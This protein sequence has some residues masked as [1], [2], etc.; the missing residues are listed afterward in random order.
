MDEAPDSRAP[1]KKE[2]SEGEKLLHNMFRLLQVVKIHQANNKLFSDSVVAFRQVLM[3]MW[4]E[5]SVAAFA[6]Y[7]GRFYLNDTRIVYTPSMWATSAKMM[8]YFQQ[9]NLAGIKFLQWEKLEDK[10]IVAFMDIFNRAVR[11][12]D[13]ST[14]LKEEVKEAFPWVSFSVDE[15]MGLSAERAE[16]EETGAIGRTS[17]IRGAPSKNLSFI[18]RQTYSQALTAMRTIITRITHGKTA[19]IQKA[20]RA[21][22]ELIDLLFDDEAIFLALSSIRDIGD[23]LYTHSVNVAIL[24]LGM[25]HRLG[26]SRGLLEQL[27]I[28]GLF[29]DLGKVGLDDHF[30]KPERL[31]GDSLDKM[32]SHSLAG[33]FNVI[34]LNAS[35]GL[36]RLI[37]GPVGEHH[38]GMDH[39]GYPKLMNEQEPISL[40]GRLVSVADQYDAL[41]SF[42]PWRPEP[43]SP[44]EALIKLME[45]SG[46]QLDPVV[47]KLFVS[48]LG[49][50]PPGS[51]LILD[52]HEVAMARYTPST[53]QAL[54]QAR[55]LH[56]DGS[57][58]FRAGELVELSEID[59]STGKFKR[60]II[61]SVHPSTL[62]I[63]P[64]DYLLKQSFED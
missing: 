25:G 28:C 26:M 4:E 27:G 49:P 24:V 55:L 13:P 54:P 8:E 42:R 62:N 63:Q 50:W 57:G 7:R 59:T 14:W 33:V 20:K 56:D 23:Q 44:H 17:I 5:N 58:G 60:N 38:M 32:Q 45:S 31:T 48:M 37:L 30:A 15:D 35:F 43:Y 64:V 3:K 21:I 47:L 18:A 61:S 10:D 34:S 22:Q 9:R 12:E 39:S 11:Q 51:V 46:T 41:T 53:S 16:L 6:L 19:G 52:T 1:Q 36:K 29:H 40:F 2:A